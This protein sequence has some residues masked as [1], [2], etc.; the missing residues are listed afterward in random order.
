MTPRKLLIL[1]IVALVAIVGG[2]WLAN[3][4]S[5]APTGAASVLYPDLRKELDSV[6]S[7]RIFK[8]GDVQAVELTRKEAGWGVAERGGYPADVPKLRKLLRALAD[9]KIYEEKT[10]DAEQYKNLGVEDTSVA[11][12]A[13]VRIEIVGTAKP[14]NVIVGKPGIG[15]QSNY[16]RRAGE[17]QSWL[18]KADIDA[19]SSPEEWLDKGLI[20]VSADR[21]Q[22]AAITMPKARPYT[23]TKNSRSD[24]NF[25][26]T[27][28]P[29]GKELS[30][31]SA[32]NS[33]ATALT[34]VTLADV[35]PAKDQAATEPAAR[36]TYRTFDGLVIEIDGWARD[37]R[38]YIA[39]RTSFDPAQAERFKAAT[40]PAEAQTEGKPEARTPQAPAQPA[41]PDVPKQVETINAKASGWVYEIAGY[42]YDAIFK[43][44]DE[45]LKK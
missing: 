18:V 2:V 40:T 21:I 30:S 14:V 36:V 41:T 9:A 42:K 12:A 4:Q 23:A 33:F 20:D 28:L 15:P 16:V 39:L 45:L 22:S 29:K 1:G 31:P 10:A 32:A 37:D 19:P 26:I 5:G 3:R 7:V 8:A 24:E 17:P 34:S 38:H 35:Q 11:T 43:P 44:L 27:G 25:T 6:S 13:G